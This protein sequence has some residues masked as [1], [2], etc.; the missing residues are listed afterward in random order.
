MRAGPRQAAGRRT[1][2]SPSG[3]SS[4][5]RRGHPRIGRAARREILLM[6]VAGATCGSWSVRRLAGLRVFRAAA[7]AARRRRRRRRRLRGRV[8]PAP[9]APRGRP[10]QSRSGAAASARRA[11]AISISSSAASMNSSSGS[12]AGSGARSRSAG[13]CALWSVRCD[14]PAGSGCRRRRTTWNATRSI[15]VNAARLVENIKSDRRGHAR[16]SSAFAARL[17]PRWRGMTSAEDRSSA[18]AGPIAVGQGT[19]LVSAGL[20]A[21]A[22]ATSQAGR[23][24]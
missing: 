22:G 1:R 12:A 4:P 3:C 15:S 23:N 17:L 19:E 5:R 11:S 13:R 21:G 8:S 20:A 18:E 14:A 10:R 9:R 7:A 2:G 24:G 6:I 16:R